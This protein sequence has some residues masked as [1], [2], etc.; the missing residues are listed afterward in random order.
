MKYLLDTDICVYISN[1]APARVIDYLEKLEQGDVG[2]SVVTYLELVYGAY[3]SQHVEANLAQA[4]RLRA[5]VPVLPLTDGVA[6][7]YGR[8]RL[9]LQR[10]GTPIGAH[11]LL[12]AAHALFHDLTLVTN[13]VREFRRVKGLR[14]ENWVK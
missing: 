2:I 9:A 3:R 5:Q 4:E 1:R 8:I 11:D 6:H 14:I 13:N 10:N 7:T 12:I